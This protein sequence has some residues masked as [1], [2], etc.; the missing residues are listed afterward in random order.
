[1]YAP[2]EIQDVIVKRKY[3][4]KN[5]LAKLIIDLLREESRWMWQQEINKKSQLPINNNEL[6]AADKE[7]LLDKTNGDL[8]E[9]TGKENI[10]LDDFIMK[11]PHIIRFKLYPNKE[12]SGK[13]I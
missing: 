4:K 3:M 8:Y 10:D 12:E 1:M 11:N 9:I 2:L 13:M 5:S 7:F 6:V